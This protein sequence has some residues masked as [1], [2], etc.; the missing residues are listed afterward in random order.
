MLNEVEL[1]RA[2]RHPHILYLEEIH[3]SKNSIYLVMEMLEGGELVHKISEEKML[4]Q[5]EIRKIIGNLVSALAYLEEK[6]IM[7]R[8]LKPENLIL[9]NKKD[10]TNICIVD[11]GLGSF[12]DVDE[13]IFKRCG[14]PGFVAPEIA[15]A[16]SNSNI[17]FDAKC[18]VF[19]A[20][21]IFYI[22]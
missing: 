12:I 4:K 2:C 21:I 1:L 15:N 20:G 16:S 14:T 9:K 19:S 5:E 6:R 8:D 17:K 10:N 3:E 7:H 18:D 22:L 11:F 13:Y